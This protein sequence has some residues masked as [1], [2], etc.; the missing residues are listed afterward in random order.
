MTIAPTGIAITWPVIAAF[1][2]FDVIIFGIAAWSRRRAAQLQR[3]LYLDDYLGMLH[4]VQD[5]H[6]VLAASLTEQEQ[7]NMT[8]HDTTAEKT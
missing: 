7:I 1:L 2:A 8:L 5:I 3:A 4:L 6:E